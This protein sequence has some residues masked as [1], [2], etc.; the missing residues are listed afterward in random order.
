MPPKFKQNCKL[1]IITNLL[2]VFYISVFGANFEFFIHVEKVLVLAATISWHFSRI[3]LTVL[4]YNST[5]S[6]KKKHILTLYLSF[7]NRLNESFHR[8]GQ[9][10]CEIF[11]GNHVGDISGPDQWPHSVKTLP[12]R[13]DS[14]YGYNG[15][16]IKF[17]S[18]RLKKKEFVFMVHYQIM[19]KFISETW[20]CF[21][22][23]I[24]FY[25]I[26]QHINYIITWSLATSFIS[27]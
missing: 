22:S 21:S 3:L 17:S 23:F 26:Q 8:S 6:V 13:T 4:R 10:F 20:T 1:S 19:L 25:F 9:L 16:N 27:V 15:A 11:S 24:I 2:Y 12:V 14:C 5:F 7:Y 18:F